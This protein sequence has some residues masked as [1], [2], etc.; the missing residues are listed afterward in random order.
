MKKIQLPTW[1]TYVLFALA[2]GMCAFGAY[3][4]EWKDVMRKAIAICMECIG[5]G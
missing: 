2:I 4:G 1:L 5:I 3:R